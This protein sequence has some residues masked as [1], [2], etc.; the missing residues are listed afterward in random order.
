MLRRVLLLTCLL[1]G[2]AALAQEPSGC[3]KFRWPIA[4]EQALLKDAAASAANIELGDIPAAALRLKLAPFDQ[5]TLAMPPERAPRDTASSAGTIRIAHVA[6][7]GVYAVSISTYAWIDAIQNGKYGK[8]LAFS[9][10]TDCAHIRKVVKYRL[11]P[12]PLTI[13]LTGVAGDAI[14]VAITPSAE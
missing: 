8:T 1:P 12:G 6:T 10:A 11:E 2:S 7:A 9:G 3:D 4:H 13:Q 14:A 5:V